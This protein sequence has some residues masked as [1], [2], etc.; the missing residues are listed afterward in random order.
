LKKHDLLQANRFLDG[1]LTEHEREIFEGLM[2]CQP[3]LMRYVQRIR[4]VDSS[5]RSLETIDAPPVK[6][7]SRSLPGIAE[8]LAMKWR[9]PAVPTAV[10]GILLLALVGWSLGS[11]R[12]DKPNAVHTNIKLVYFSKTA[13]AVSVVGSFNEWKEEVPLQ[14]RGDNGYWIAQIPVSPGEYTYSFLID[15]K[16]R[17]ADPTA[18]SFLEDDFGSKNSVI[19]VGI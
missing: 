1:D 12:I 8:L 19:R 16:T 10:A 7:P 11:G 9:I 4:N 3:D 17:I 14:S 15:G 5:L 2:K 13:A 6:I 18:E